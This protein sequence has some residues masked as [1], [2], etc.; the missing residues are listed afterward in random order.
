MLKISAQLNDR[1][2]QGTAE[3]LATFVSEKLAELGFGE[4]HRYQH[5]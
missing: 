4:R 1:D 3:E 2:F 5:P